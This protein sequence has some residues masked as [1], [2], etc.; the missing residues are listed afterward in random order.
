MKLHQGFIC[1]D[2]VLDLL[3]RVTFRFTLPVIA[4]IPTTLFRRWTIPGGLN[5]L[6]V[7]R[8]NAC[9]YTA[10]KMRAHQS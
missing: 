2:E 4:Q 8:M 5:Y 6:L 1:L 3:W 7:I 10:L 9:T